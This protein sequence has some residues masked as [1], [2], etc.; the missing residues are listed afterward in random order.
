MNRESFDLPGGTL[1]AL[2]FG[3]R[4]QPP[5]VVFCHANG[6]NAQ[7][8]RAVLEPLGVPALALDLRGHG[9]TDLPTDPAA[10]SSWQIFADDI[11]D[12][13]DR[14]IDAP[15]ILAGHSYGAVS[16]ILSLPRTQSKVR[17]YVGFDPVLIP[18]LFQMV[19][20]SSLGRSYMKRRVPMARKAGQRTAVFESVEAAV[21]RYRGRGAFKGVPDAIL[22]DYI[23]GGTKPNLDPLASDN[24]AGI[25]LT[26]DPL[27][28]Q[29][30]F[31]AHSHN[32]YRAIPHLPDQSVIVFAGRHG[33][34][35]SARQRAKI[36]KLQPKISVRLEEGRDHLFPLHDPDF[37]RG[38]I[39]A[40]LRVNA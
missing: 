15:V 17:A 28:E 11:A 31:C 19:T 16:A 12:F 6:F 40:A 4:T 38:V 39:E 29:A 34:V 5:H 3:D 18:R 24:T 26:C 10:L 7:S 20:R 9:L 2:R 13:F 25:R 33:R 27:W 30:I 1:S 23:E 37:A 22:R 21:D 36:A 32:V 8:Y 35:S 14:Y